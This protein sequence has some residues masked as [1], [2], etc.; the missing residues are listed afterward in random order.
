M[1]HGAA[2]ALHGQDPLVGRADELELLERLLDELGHGRPAAVELSGELGIGKTRLLAELAA[3]AELRGYLVLSGSASELE[4]ELPFSVFVHALDDYVG[5][6]EPDQLSPLADDVRAELTHVFPALSCLAAEQEV[7]LQHERYRSHRAVRALLERLAQRRPLVLLLDDFHWADPASV[8]LLGAM[9]RRPPAAAVLIAM[10]FRARQLPER[11]EAAHE[12]AHRE[13]ALARIELDAL[14]PLEALELIGGQLDAAVADALYAE[15][16][17]NPF[18]LEQ[19]VRS[20]ERSGGLTPAPG[21]E[22]SLTA[23]GVP[24]AVGAALFEEFALLS[25]S[26][27]LVLEGAAVASDPFEPELAAA[28]A[29]TAEP[30]TMDAIDQ[31]LRLD[32]IRA[33]DVPRRFRFRHPLIRRAV[34]DATPGGWRLAAHERCA[35]A[36]AANGASAAARAHHVEIS[37][38]RGDLAAVSL[39]R[40]AGEATAR[41]A[42]ASAARWFGAALRFLPA[43]APSEERVTLL[44]ARAGSLAATGRLAESRAALLECLDLAPPEWRVRVATACATVERLLGLQHEA[45][46]HLTAALSDLQCAES[47]EAVALMIEL[48]SD[49]LQTGDLVTMRSWAGRAVAAA[50]RL[51]DRG[52]LAAALAVRAWS[53]AFAGDGEQA[54]RHCDE[55]A[56]IIDRL[57]NEELAQRLDSLANLASAELYL[58]RFSETTRHAQRALEI[59]R[60]T[61]RGELFPLIVA[62]L[63]GSLW[64]QGK[65][66]EAEELFDGAVEA[67]RLA[68]NVQ[69]LAWTLFNLSFAALVAGNIEVAFTAAEESVEL[70]AETE[71]GLIST[72]AAATF[73][74]T[75]LEAGEPDRSIEALLSGAGGEELPLIGGGWRA[76]FL[77]VLAR[78]LLATGKQSEARRAAAAAQACADTVALPSA[79]AMATLASAAV[80]LDEGEPASAAGQALAAAAAFEAVAALFDAA[81]A[82]ELAGRALAEAG[83]AE[84]AAAELE[85]A[86]AAFD[87]FGSLRYRDQ[88]EREL[89]KLGRRIHRR[90]RPGERDTRGLAALTGRELEIAQ[91]VADRKTN[92]EIA[93]ELFLSPKTVETHLRNIFRKIDVASRVELAR[94]V[95]HSDRA[96]YVTT[97]P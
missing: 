78:A 42:P 97:L 80:A 45:H 28:A 15:S 19:L 18:Y 56:E 23:V 77:E 44:L 29:A 21:D 30:A 53:G 20:L 62:M 76:R 11:L 40:E 88:A 83:D 41:L 72:L 57:P 43:A 82:R 33:T 3:R 65:P 81:R 52:L 48:T 86:A 14:T 34:Y 4:R 32:L 60:A 10:A 46:A 17:G 38:R 7:A 92:P 63:G 90:T 74:A 36:L 49:A 94:A 16:G 64:V 9:L 12:R 2:A 89:R 22:L 47:A 87:S 13:G 39:L 67:A 70:A 37:A 58:D 61:G 93:A 96:T 6:L 31:L 35:Q 75:L 91:L 84:R 5:S 73:A 27:R 66:L 59:G 55:A 24:P 54:K 95:E 25:E 71:P 51:A 68:G 1:T 8:E 85:R 79:T 50:T 26:V 69:N